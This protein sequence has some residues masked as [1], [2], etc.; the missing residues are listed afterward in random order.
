MVQNYYTIKTNPLYTTTNQ[1]STKTQTK[2]DPVTETKVIHYDKW[3]Y[4]KTNYAKNIYIYFRVISFILEIICAV[5]MIRERIKKI[6]IISFCLRKWLWAHVL[7]VVI[8]QKNRYIMWLKE[9][10][11][12]IFKITCIKKDYI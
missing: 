4:H 11:R 2:K 9:I 3:F 12:I 7:E 8:W 5:I 10:A 6:T 1:S